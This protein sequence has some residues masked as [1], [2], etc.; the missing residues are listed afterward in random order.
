MLKRIRGAIVFE[1]D[2]CDE[3]IE[4]E[5]RDFQISIETIREN[6]WSS[7]KVAGECLHLCPSCKET[8]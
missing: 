8:E 6:G 5:T 3:E 7:E 1:C 4:T 2:R